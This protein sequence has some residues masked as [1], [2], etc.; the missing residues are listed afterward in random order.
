VRDVLDV[1]SYRGFWRLAVKQRRNAVDEVRRSVSKQRFAASAARLIP[2]VTA[3]D[4]VPATS[5]IRAQAVRPDGSLVDD[6]LI[7]RKART[8][9]VLNAPSPAATS[10]LE[11]GSYVARLAA[12]LDPA[13]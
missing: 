11:I 4:L 7:V 2:A 6:F 12:Q 1:L 3:A 13:A 5:G 8:L 10:S 9:H